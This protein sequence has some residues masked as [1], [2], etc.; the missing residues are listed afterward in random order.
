MLAEGWDVEGSSEMGLVVGWH[1]GQGPGTSRLRCIGKKES[2]RQQTRTRRRE[3]SRS[4]FRFKW[5]TTSWDFECLWLSMGIADL[6][7]GLFRSRE[8]PNDWQRTLLARDVRARGPPLMIKSRIFQP[9]SY[10]NHI[11]RL[12]YLCRSS[13]TFMTDRRIFVF[14]FDLEPP[15]TTCTDNC[16]VNSYGGDTRGFD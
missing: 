7:V 4:P 15:I 8:E 16:H 5:R 10:K 13:F 12:V 3:E 11:Y 2:R 1:D 6:L 9:D 14:I